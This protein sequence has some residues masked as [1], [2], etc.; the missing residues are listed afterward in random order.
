VDLK[1]VKEKEKIKDISR[2]KEYKKR[3]RRAIE[4]AVLILIIE[5]L[6]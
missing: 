1:E 5:K 4:R 3:F 2:L 6:K